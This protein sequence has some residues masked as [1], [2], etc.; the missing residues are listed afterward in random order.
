MG[1]SRIQQRLNV[2]ELCQIFPALGGKLPIASELSCCSR[3]KH[4]LLV[5]SVDVG[6]QFVYRCA[7]RKVPPRLCITHRL[8]RSGIGE[9]D[10]ERETTVF[11][12][13]A[14]E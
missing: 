8:S 13:L 7:V 10:F 1:D 9:F 11:D 12:N 4:K 2:F 5:A 14:I 3:T 6:N